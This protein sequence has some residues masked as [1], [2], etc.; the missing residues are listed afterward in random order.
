MDILIP[1]VLNAPAPIPFKVSI[2]TM[3]EATA[4]DFQ[5]SSKYVSF[6]IGSSVE[7]LTVRL[8]SHSTAGPER[9]LRLVLAQ[10]QLGTGG[11]LSMTEINIRD[12]ILVAPKIVDYKQGDDLGKGCGQGRDEFKR[13]LCSSE[14]RSIEVLG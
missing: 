12:Q 7:Y 3:G 9:R 10:N 1:V 11:V 4:S 5:L 13:R 6:G 8:L 14:F 2:E